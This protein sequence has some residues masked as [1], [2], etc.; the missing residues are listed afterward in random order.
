MPLCMEGAYS[1]RLFSKQDYLQQEPGLEFIDLPDALEREMVSEKSDS[2]LSQV[3]ERLSHAGVSRRDQGRYRAAVCAYLANPSQ[4]KRGIGAAERQD[5]EPQPL[6]TFRQPKHYFHPKLAF[7]ESMQVMPALHLLFPLRARLTDRAQAGLISDTIDGERVLKAFADIKEAPATLSPEERF[8]VRLNRIMYA[9]HEPFHV[10]QAGQLGDHLQTLISE[11]R[12]E[13]VFDPVET[14]RL[15]E[16][17][18]MGGNTT[19]MKGIPRALD[20]CVIGLPNEYRMDVF[21]GVSDHQR[22]WMAAWYD[23]TTYLDNQFEGIMD[24]ISEDGLKPLLEKQPALVLWCHNTLSVCIAGLQ[25][26]K[27]R[28]DEGKAVSDIAAQRLFA[29]LAFIEPVYFSVFQRSDAGIEYVREKQS[30]PALLG[31]YLNGSIIET[32][33]FTRLDIENLR[34][35]CL[36]G[37]R[38]QRPLEGGVRTISSWSYPET[39]RTHVTSVQ[40]SSFSRAEDREY[41]LTD[42]G[43]KWTVEIVLAAAERSWGFS[44]LEAFFQDIQLTLERCDSDEAGCVSLAN[45]VRE[46]LGLQ[47]S[48]NNVRELFGVAW[49]LRVRIF[50]EDYTKRYVLRKAIMSAL[51]KRQPEQAQGYLQ[52]L[53][54]Q[55]ELD[56]GQYMTLLGFSRG[57]LEAVPARYQGDPDLQLRHVF[58][59]DEVRGSRSFGMLGL[60]VTQL[61][62]EEKARLKEMLEEARRERD[63]LL[64]ETSKTWIREMAQWKRRQVGMSLPVHEATA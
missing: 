55:Y 6:V 56:P 33:P 48:S 42:V 44:R 4:A 31:R 17:Y 5:Q 1:A 23:R 18:Q 62:S 22:V 59:W 15:I 10:I 57:D 24:M 21:D 54:F 8:L 14:K 19:E 43:V 37:L 16:S 39:G 2:P 9:F 41:P 38:E 27:V 35:D 11:E 13:D 25:A 40:A 49:H 36:I 51:E 46:T 64:V 26:L 20:T 28:L 58:T 32:E 61:L 53:F 47:L 45:Q 50:R 7:T 34:T 3:C 29:T 63:Y 60:D 52:G 12:L 30:Q